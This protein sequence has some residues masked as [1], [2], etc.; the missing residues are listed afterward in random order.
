MAKFYS[1]DELTSLVKYGKNKFKNLCNVLKFLSDDN[2]CNFDDWI[3]N[4]YIPKTKDNLDYIQKQENCSCSHDIIHCFTVINKINNNSIIVGSECIKKF[5]GEEANETKRKL[6]DDFEGKKKCPSCKETV[7]KP[8]VERYKH[9]ENI[10]HLKCYHGQND[11]EEVLPPAPP[12][13]YEETLL[14]NTED[15]EKE[16]LGFGK[17]KQLTI[18]QA[19]LNN[20][21]RWYYLEKLPYNE[22]NSLKVKKFVDYLKL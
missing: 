5:F 6:M 10:Y 7:Y 21:V 3:P 12:P 15:Y 19:S 13:P 11:I 1:Y 4:R 2:K 18:K 20:G 16:L 9:E 17:Y 14:N 22:I 8:V